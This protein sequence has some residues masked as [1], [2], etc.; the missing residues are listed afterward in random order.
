MILDEVDVGED[1]VDYILL[2]WAD[3]QRI[4]DAIANSTNL[5]S[6]G[7]QEF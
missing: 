3:V 1:G 2:P 5:L 4:G 6:L 7:I